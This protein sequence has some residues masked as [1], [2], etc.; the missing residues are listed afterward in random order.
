MV[1]AQSFLSDKIGAMDNLSQFL[2]TKSIR[3][4]EFADAISISRPYLSLLLSGQ[5]RPSLDLALRIAD[6]TGGAVPVTSW[7]RE[8]AE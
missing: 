4:Q 1:D 5:K 2:K 8:P 3:Q 7:R 6:A